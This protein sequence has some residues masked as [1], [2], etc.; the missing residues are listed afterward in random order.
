MPGAAQRASAPIGTA[1]AVEQVFRE[2]GGGRLIEARTETARGRGTIMVRFVRGTWMC[3]ATV[4]PRTGSVL[5]IVDDG[6]RVPVPTPPLSAAAPVATQLDFRTIWDV[7]AAVDD[8]AVAYVATD[9]GVGRVRLGRDLAWTLTVEDHHGT[10]F[11]ATR[12]V[13]AVPGGVV[14]TTADGRAFRLDADGRRCW[15]TWLPAAPHTIVADPGGNRLLLATDA[16]ALEVN[17]ATG[18]VLGVGGGPVRAA[19]Y[20]PGGGHLLA[21]HRGELLVT[22]ARGGVRRRHEQDGYVERLWAYAGKVFLAGEHGL[23]EISPG[24]GVVAQWSAP[25]A[26]AVQSAVVAGGLAFTCTRDGRV[27]R[28]D[29]ATAAWHGTLPG[30]PDH[31]SAV[32][33]VDPGAG[34]WLLTGH[35]DGRLTASAVRG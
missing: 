1:R 24:K 17:A 23:K 27:D 21:G 32:T 25:G 34:P 22:G 26:G 16:G 14:G 4:D 5:S 20:L 2:A 35:R 28:H 19:A 10:G 13:A 3:H 12:H 11:G 31:P 30:L 29:Q 33:T 6:P 9:A 8:P 15:A 7:Q 18:A